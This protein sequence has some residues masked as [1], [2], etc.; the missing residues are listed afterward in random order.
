MT[1]MVLSRWW[2]RS[3]R[4]ELYEPPWEPGLPPE[5]EARA[6]SAVAGGQ[7]LIRVTEKNSGTE[8]AQDGEEHEMGTHPAKRK[9]W[10]YA[11]L[12]LT[13]L[14]GQPGARMPPETGTMINE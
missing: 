4:E 5:N 7:K 11:D 14:A 8:R 3:G 9:P 10:S 2:Y 6:G 13:C 1:K 12:Y